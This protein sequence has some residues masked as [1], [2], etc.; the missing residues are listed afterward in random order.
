MILNLFYN[1]KV[2]YGS[3][4]HSEYILYIFLLLYREHVCYLLK[5]NG[6]DIS[7]GKGQKV[8]L[9]PEDLKA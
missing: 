9:I 7:G 4:H 6:S 8:R 1:A 5:S 3:L 2:T